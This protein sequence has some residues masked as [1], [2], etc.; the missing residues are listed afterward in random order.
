MNVKFDLSPSGID[1]AIRAVDNYK[2]W[3][4]RKSH[5]L[6]ERLAEEGYQASSFSFSWANYDGENDVDVTIES[7]G[8]HERA[9][10]AVGK[11]VLFI[12]FGTGVLGPIHSETP[13]GL[14]RGS[15]SDG[16][17]GKGHWE[18]PNGWYYA[19]GLK[20]WGNGAN[21]PMYNSVKELEEN[22]KRIVMEVFGSD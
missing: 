13:E 1:K 9:I 3:L 8:E 4:L 11:A 12:E 17:N 7:R 10:V 18:D 6:L 19:H 2:S 21:M 16:P 14:E 22:F 5:D 15:W 20:S